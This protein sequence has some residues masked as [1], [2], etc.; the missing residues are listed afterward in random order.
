MVTGNSPD[1][2]QNG[3]HVDVVPK[4]GAVCSRCVVDCSGDAGLTR[5]RSVVVITTVSRCHGVEQRHTHVDEGCDRAGRGARAMTYLRVMT[6]W[7]CLP[8][9]AFKSLSHV[10]RQ[11]HIPLSPLPTYLHTRIQPC[12]PAQ[13]SSTRS[14]VC[15]H[16]C[17]PYSRR[18][19]NPPWHI[20]DLIR[21]G[22]NHHTSR[23]EE[24]AHQPYSQQTQT[25]QQRTV[26]S[27][28]QSSRQQKEAQHQ[29]QQTQ[30]HASPKYKEQV[31][32]IVQEEREEKGKM[33]VYKGL[34]DYKLIEKMG[35]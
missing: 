30:K 27:Q 12:L 17:V 13:A 29:Q 11:P 26:D 5:G 14:R 19:A 20:T 31:E 28:Q 8:L 35:E 33:P 24:S 7:S 21:H 32:Q 1:V 2:C 3:C 9:P 16:P 22:K 23:Q 6:P 15:S 25:Q 18:V 4:F 34:D 10:P